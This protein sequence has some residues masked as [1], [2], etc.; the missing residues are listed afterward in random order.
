M[1]VPLLAAFDFDHTICEDNTDYEAQK[2]LP[3][4]KIPDSVR[5]FYK[6]DNWITYMGKIFELLNENSIDL[7][8]IKTTINEIP[9][10]PGIDT[11]LTELYSQ[12]CEIIIISDS[13]SLFIEW[14]L[15]HNG[16]SHTVKEIFSNPALIQNG[17]LKIEMYHLQDYCLLSNKNLCKG[18]ILEEYI[19]KRSLEGVCFKKIAYVGDG[20]NDFCPIL[21]LSENDVAFPRLGYSLVKILNENNMEPTRKTKADIVPW[22]TGLDILED[23][24]KRIENL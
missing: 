24:K 11:L 21:R 5:R 8:K 22:K 23:L 13:N 1:S 6:S 16:L 15:N 19:Y 14:W 12:N 2:L 20:R 9:P 10:A 18:Q 3:N 7:E 17:M 4:E